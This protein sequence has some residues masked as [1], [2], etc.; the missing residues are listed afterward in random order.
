M[1]YAVSLTVAP[2]IDN[3]DD[4]I[5]KV[6]QALD[7]DDLSADQIPLFIAQ[8]EKMFNRRLRVRQMIA[9]TTLTATARDVE[10]P[11]DFLQMRLLT[12]SSGAEVKPVSLEDVMVR[13]TDTDTVPTVYSEIGGVPKLIRLAPEPTSTTLDA[14]Y[15]A[16]I[17]QLSINQQ[18]NWLLE[19]HHDLYYYAAL[20]ACEAYLADDARLAL[21]LEA[22]ERIIGEIIAADA[23]DRHARRTVLRTDIWGVMPRVRAVNQSG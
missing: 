14:V 12:N 21:W 5:E 6:A 20:L 19:S 22:Q 10:L 23:M 4:L 15:Y 11:A 3:Y 1:S 8:A 18:T 16:A 2:T 17:P 13:Q 7:R 9:T